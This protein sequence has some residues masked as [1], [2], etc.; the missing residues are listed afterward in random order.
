MQ[1]QV[2]GKSYI[3]KVKKW[4]WL[5]DRGFNKVNPFAKFDDDAYLKGRVGFWGALSATLYIDNVIVYGKKGQ[6]D[7]IPFAVQVELKLPVVWGQLKS[8]HQS[9]R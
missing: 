3:I 7:T 6:T 9:E 8:N 1:I 4:Q 5:G 2:S